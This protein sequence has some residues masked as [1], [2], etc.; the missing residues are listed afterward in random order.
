MSTFWK[1]STDRNRFYG[2]SNN[3][4]HS[5]KKK[6]IKLTEYTSYYYKRETRYTL[7]EYDRLKI[8]ESMMLG[9]VFWA[10]CEAEK[11]FIKE[12]FLFYTF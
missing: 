7:T 5:D 10:N 12:I 1:E 3:K 2:C 9:R 11:I 8:F 4:D 6:D